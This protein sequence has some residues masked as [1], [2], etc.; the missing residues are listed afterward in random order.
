MFRRRAGPLQAGA[1]GDGVLEQKGRQAEEALGGR[2][3]P[4]RH[5]P[6]S[7]RAP[8]PWPAAKQ[9]AL[10]AAG[11]SGP[12]WA[13]E[14]ATSTTAPELLSG[15][16]A[17]YS[18]P[19]RSRQAGPRHAPLRIPHHITPLLSP[20][21]TCT[22]P[23]VHRTLRTPNP[24]C[25]NHRDYCPRASQPRPPPPRLVTPEHLWGPAQQ[26]RPQLALLQ[27]H[28]PQPPSNKGTPRRGRPARGPG[29]A[30]VAASGRT[31]RTCRSSTQRGSHARLQSHSSGF[32][33]RFLREAQGW[34]LSGWQGR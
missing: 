32:P 14:K 31:T 8:R 18:S 15:R 16:Q 21:P 17:M 20:P 28:S 25:L 13:A 12:S 29:P 5:Q 22:G 6:W 4:H 9:K 2:A 24:V 34:A 27:P 7:E 11:V 30:H 1:R 23:L 3:A 33:L 19:G 26:G 10:H